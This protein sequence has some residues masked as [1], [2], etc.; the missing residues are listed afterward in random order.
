MLLALVP[1]KFLLKRT[2]EKIWTSLFLLRERNWRKKAKV[3]VS[4][5]RSE[6]MALLEGTL[7]AILDLAIPPLLKKSLLN[8]H[9]GLRTLES[10]KIPCK[11]T[12]CCAE[13]WEQGLRNHDVQHY[14]SFAFTAQ[15]WREGNRLEEC[16]L[17]ESV[18]CIIKCIA[19]RLKFNLSKFLINS[20]RNSFLYWWTHHREKFCG[21]W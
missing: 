4:P 17:E 15:Q 10:R 1:L 11:I 7:L 5:E 12:M 20:Y 6:E 21:F 2:Q 19:V 13:Q 3:E 9:K 18:K 16:S 8:P 14:S